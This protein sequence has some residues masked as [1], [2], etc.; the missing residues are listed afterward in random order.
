MV[1][2]GLESMPSAA[3]ASQLRNSM[4]KSL[5]TYTIYPVSRG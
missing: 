3:Q 2:K 4:S 5:V 1:R